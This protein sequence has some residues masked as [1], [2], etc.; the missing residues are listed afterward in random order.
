MGE[1]AAG[2]RRFNPAGVRPGRGCVRPGY[3]METAQGD[4][5]GCFVGGTRILETR[6]SRAGS[7]PVGRRRSRPNRVGKLIKPRGEEPGIAGATREDSPRLGLAGKGR[8]GALEAG[9]P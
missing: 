4:A 6:A 7:Q 5:G 9:T 1:N 2:K 3:A 8:R